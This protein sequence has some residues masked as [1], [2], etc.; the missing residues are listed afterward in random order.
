MSN[1]SLYHQQ[2]RLTRREAWKLC[3]LEAQNAPISTIPLRVASIFASGQTASIEERNAAERCCCRSCADAF[4]ASGK[5]DTSHVC[6]RCGRCGCQ[7][8]VTKC[9]DGRNQCNSRVCEL[10]S[11]LQSGSCDLGKFCFESDKLG[12]ILMH[13]WLV[14]QFK[15]ER[16]LG[17]LRAYFLVQSRYAALLCA[18]ATFLLDSFKAVRSP[19]YEP[20][21]APVC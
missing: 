16:Q 17:S 21:I 8:C 11:H 4:V 2:E 15:Q 3:F 18:Q 14:L 5:L 20:C 6:A 12:R 13:Q 7:N 10:L 1:S 9:S 19:V